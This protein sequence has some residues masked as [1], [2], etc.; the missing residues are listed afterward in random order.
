[1]ISF[2]QKHPLAMAAGLLAA[3]F[4]GPSPATTLP[5]AG[6]ALELAATPDGGW[7]TLDKRGLHLLD[8]AGTERASLPMRAKQLDTRTLSDGVLALVVDSN[9]DR[10]IPVTV[11]LKQGKLQAGEP[12]PTPD[13]GVEAS[14]LY[15]DGQ[16]AD[17]VF[18]IAKDGQAEQWLLHGGRYR[19]VR[20]L[21]LPTHVK[22]CRG[23]DASHS[24]LVS[25]AGFG[26]WAYGADAEGSPARSAVALK[27]PYGTLEG[28]AGTLALLPGGVAVLDNKGRNL[29]LLRFQ[30]GSWKEIASPHVKLP[31][32][33]RQMAAV[34]KNDA[35]QLLVRDEDSNRWQSYS[36][37]W[38]PAAAQRGA[39]T[40]PIVPPTAQT[41]PVARQGDAADD[42][43]IW[44]DPADPSRSRVLGTNKKQGLL[45]YDLQGKQL[46]LL[47]VGRLNN[48]DLRQNVTM[49]GR[50]VDLALATQRDDNTMVLFTID[51][52]GVVTE[53]AR[54]PTGLEQIYGTCL[55]QPASGGLEAFV[56]DKD[57]E[58]QHYRIDAKGD[59]FAATLL[60][61]FSV[62][63]Q[64]EG[65]V[66]D[67]RRG[68]L[69][70]GE[71]KRGVW[72]TPAAADHAG[73]LRMILPVG[74]QLTADVEGIAIYRGKPGQSDYLVISSQG[75]NS[76]VVLDATPPY[77]VRGAFR[78]GYN[79]DAGIDGTSET[80]GLDVT[81][82]ALGAAYPDGM[83]AIQDGYKRLPDGTQNF[84]YVSWTEVAKVLGLGR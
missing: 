22:H 47:E 14:C 74:P 46:Q 83:L 8:A 38:Q 24:L 64:P 73:P 17:H 1:M 61:R 41:E 66:A 72:V 29:H 53:A 32:G 13:F 82:A 16:Q 44:V 23:D 28:G 27:R 67:D 3:C 9:S 78:V 31:G 20:K 2:I 42:P 21:A 40:L 81:S 7:L 51:A 62:A 48:V 65:C 77:R 75:S 80:D 50:Q 63:T 55:Y 84:K 30:A 69:F 18:L 36:Q 4:A 33:A 15:R 60:R 59:G 26:V 35:M 34:V 54:F 12:F 76:Y 19:L 57:G 37:K 70:I 58:Y 10:A 5:A 71:E 6:S 43:A 39:P 11:D 25:E 52:A 45:V 49:G 79:L 68:Q 56:N